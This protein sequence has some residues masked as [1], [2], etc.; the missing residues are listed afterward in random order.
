MAR[1]STSLRLPE[2]RQGRYRGPFHGI[3]NSREGTQLTGQTRPLS[4]DVSA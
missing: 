1:E 2:R 3:V 4:D